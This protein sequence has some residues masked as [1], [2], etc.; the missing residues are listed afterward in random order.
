MSIPAKQPKVQP[1][2]QPQMRAFWQEP[3][4]AERLKNSLNACTAVHKKDD[5]A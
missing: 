3:W 2:Q 1:R 5:K 4:K